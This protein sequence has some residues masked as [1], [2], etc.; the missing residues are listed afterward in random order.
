MVI[1]IIVF[2]D[3]SLIL[4]CSF[5][6]NMTNSMRTPMKVELSFNDSNSVPG[7]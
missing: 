7:S 6:F 4:R 3:N 1:V 2:G 5:S